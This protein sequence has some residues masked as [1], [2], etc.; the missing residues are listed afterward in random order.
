MTTPKAITFL[1]GIFFIGLL[2]SWMLNGM[3]F[4]TATRAIL[5]SLTAIKVYDIWGMFKIPWVN[6]DFF[7]IGLP[8]LLS[9][10]FAFFGGTYGAIQYLLYIIAM[11]I[12]WG[13]VVVVIG[14]IYSFWSRGR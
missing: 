2:L 1:G 4:N 5:G 7:T 9:F 12:V 8:K 13:I 14:V 10:D 11:G 3:W 6:M